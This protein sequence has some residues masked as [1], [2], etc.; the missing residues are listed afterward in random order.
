MK[1]HLL[2]SMVL[3]SICCAVAAGRIVYV[4]TDAAG[5][6]DG[7]TWTDAYRYLQDAL[8]IAS[9]GDEIRVAQGVYRPDDFVLSR[10]PNLGRAETFQLKNDVAIKGGYAG[11]GEPDPNERDTVL[12]ETI[13]TGDLNGD[14][15][16]GLAYK[17]DNSFHIVTA[18]DTNET[19]ILDGFTVTGG[20]AI[21]SSTLYECG[22]GMYCVGDA[23]VL[24]CRFTGNVAVVGGGLGSRGP[25]RLTLTGC[26]FSANEAFE[27]GGIYND[28]TVPI[29]TDCNFCA[30]IADQGG[31]GMYNREESHAVIINCTFSGNSARY[32]GGIHNRSSSPTLTNCTFN[33]NSALSGAAISNEEF[34]APILDYCTFTA[35]AARNCGGAMHSE[36]ENT[37]ILL[38]NCLFAGNSAA[39]G[40]AISNDDCHQILTGCT[41]TGN[42]TR[43]QYSGPIDNDENQCT[44][45]NC[46]FWNN[47]DAHGQVTE[48][49]LAGSPDVIAVNYC[50]VQGWTGVLGGTGNID[51]DPCFADP[52]YLDPNGTP[53][54]ANDDFWVD[55][56]YHLKSQAGRWDPQ[57]QGWVQDNVTSPCI[58][59]GNPMSPIGPEPFPNGGI[60]N[61]G[62][63]GGTTEAS[64]SYFGEPVCETIVA[65]DVNGDCTVDF[66]DFRIM[67]FHWLED[68]SHNN[69]PADSPLP[70][71]MKGYELYSWP[72]EH[73]WHFTLITGTNR[74]KSYEE[75]YSDESVITDDG[76]VKIRD[77]RVASLKRTLE[78]LPAGE[79]VFWSDDRFLSGEQGD[80]PNI[81]FPD[82]EVISEIEIHCNHLGL[83]LSGKLSHFLG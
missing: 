45:A 12:Y 33:G 9:A 76:W 14:D 13:L 64:K 40:G 62:A 47:L 21:S 79:S 70:T 36:Q 5:T 75:I 38:N 34:S 41:F 67:A 8:M 29:L 61:M 30:N 19:A 37:L 63:C 6:N 46:I 2:T 66:N 78:R 80:M 71:S 54:D 58:D 68:R 65:G 35:N 1:G 31:G 18:L 55:G 52:G 50:C 20:Y 51:A 53:Q 27:G 44:L 56:D 11:L 22:G 16:L 74:T 24:D 49:A 82:A 83:E 73:D 32:G 60:I 4:D 10:R 59:T 57:T 43:D 25:S 17:S 69:D 81:S 72:V 42:I 48:Q 23:T 3:V 15:H 28:D 39:W 77:K 7:S 26:N